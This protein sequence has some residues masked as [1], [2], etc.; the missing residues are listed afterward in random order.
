[1][2]QIE[3]DYYLIE[4]KMAPVQYRFVWCFVRIQTIVF[5]KYISDLEEKNTRTNPELKQI[6]IYFQYKVYIIMAC[7][8]M[9]IQ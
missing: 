9:A 7:N 2:V 8:A 4:L 5:P 6:K 3:K 1:M